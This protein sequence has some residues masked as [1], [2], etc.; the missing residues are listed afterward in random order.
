[1]HPQVVVK[2]L[3]VVPLSFHCLLQPL[4]KLL[5][6]RV[7]SWRCSCLSSVHHSYCQFVVSFVRRPSKC[8]LSASWVTFNSCCQ[9]WCLPP[10]VSW[11]ILSSASS[12]LR[13][14]L[15]K[16]HQCQRCPAC[17]CQSNNS[18]AL[19]NLGSQCAGCPLE[20]SLTPTHLLQSFPLM[21]QVDPDFHQRP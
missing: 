3:F 16:R 10:S 19:R 6:K 13:Y 8:F 21:K 14:P 9:T 1:M 5:N 17:L 15:H 2:S 12:L 11:S 4:M 7:A 20:C 18:Q